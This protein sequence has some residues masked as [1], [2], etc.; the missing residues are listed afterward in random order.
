MKT[1]IA[2]GNFDGVHLGH[3]ALFDKAKEIAFENGLSPLV[4]TFNDNPANFLTPY[5]PVRQI[6]P[7]REKK[8]RIQNNVRNVYFMNF[9]DCV[10]MSAREFFL[11]LVN[12]FNARAFV[13]GFN[14]SF[15]KGREGTPEML[16][17]LCDEFN[18]RCEIVGGVT[19]GDIVIS[20]TNI[21]RL[22]SMGRVVK[23]N[24]LLT[25]PYSVTAKSVSGK[26][27]G[28]K[29]GYPTI[30]QRIDDSKVR[31]PRGVY[32]TR[33]EIKGKSYRSV[34]NIGFCPTF[35]DREERI[36]THIIDRKT[37]ELKNFNGFARVVFYDRIRD[38]IAFSS[39]EE[40][41]AQIAKDISA[42][43]EYFASKK[44]K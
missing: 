27:V 22:I 17:S 26:K 16:K 31:L 29:I 36:E 7:K 13:C 41:K 30:N 14:F 10:D 15:G 28:R 2:L 21:R 35:G 40:L 18:F 23:A 44:A 19:D 6:T 3:K 37:K 4:F 39:K 42:C 24:S 9:A 32:I 5:H 43:R 38:E 25:E 33:T 1:V 12:K 34:T 8:R 20:S 11:F